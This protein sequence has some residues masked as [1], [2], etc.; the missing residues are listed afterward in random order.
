MLSQHHSSCPMTWASI[1]SSSSRRRPSSQ[2]RIFMITCLRH[3]R[4]YPRLFKEPRV[5]LH[6]S[7]AIN[8]KL[9][10]VP[11]VTSRVIPYSAQ[12]ADD[13]RIST[14]VDGLRAA[15]YVITSWQSP[16]PQFLQQFTNWALV[17]HRFGSRP[18]R[19]QQ[20]PARTAAAVCQPPGWTF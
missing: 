6:L 15:V 5:A 17:Y 14:P 1:K 18:L 11:R 4:G 9:F 10:L 19:E 16:R 2:A 7:L 13:C 20:L 12:I 3:H 8:L